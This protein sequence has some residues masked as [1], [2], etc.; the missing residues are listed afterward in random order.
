M[1]V[2]NIIGLIGFFIAIFSVGFEATLHGIIGVS[3]IAITLLQSLGGLLRFKMP[4][5]QIWK[6]FHSF[7]GRFI[8][9]VCAVQILIGYVL[10]QDGSS[11]V[12]ILG[13]VHSGLLIILFLLVRRRLKFRESEQISGI[14]EEEPLPFEPVPVAEP[15]EEPL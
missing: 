2:V 5:R 4:S 12:L 8:L 15:K 1:F 9:L 13:L 11:L 10:L 6:K 3:L 14:T 7:T